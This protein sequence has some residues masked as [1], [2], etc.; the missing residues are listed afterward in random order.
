M[1]H[2]HIKYNLTSSELLAQTSHTQAIS[3]ALLGPL[4]DRV[5]CGQWVWEQRS[6][7]TSAVLLP[8]S[9]VAALATNWSQFACLRALT[10]STFQVRRRRPPRLGHPPAAALLLG[11]LQGRAGQRLASTCALR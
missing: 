7:P 11:G 8:L 4:V 5:I 9:C 1:R 2:Y 6:T 10:P 3:L